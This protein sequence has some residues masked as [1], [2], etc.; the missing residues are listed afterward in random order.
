MK[1]SRIRIYSANFVWFNLYFFIDVFRIMSQR[2]NNLGKKKRK[3]IMTFSKEK[4]LNEWSKSFWAIVGSIL[5]Y[6]KSIKHIGY[7]KAV[8]CVF[9]FFFEDIYPLYIRDF[10]TFY[11]QIWPIFYKINLVF[12]CI[13]FLLTL[14]YI[15]NLLTEND[16]KWY[17]VQ[18]IFV[19]SMFFFF[20]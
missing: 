3:E 15:T 16:N 5:R 4:G 13:C 19:I 12:G 11:C 2:L 20:H 10:F 1:F 14:G 7:S 9:F 6:L 8:P 17:Y 18:N